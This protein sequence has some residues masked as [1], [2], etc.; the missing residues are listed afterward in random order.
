M[1]PE[2]IQELPPILAAWSTDSDALVRRWHLGSTRA[3]RALAGYLAE[4]L[5]R[6]EAEERIRGITLEIRLGGEDGTNRGD[7]GLAEEI[8]GAIHESAACA[9]RARKTRDEPPKP[10]PIRARKRS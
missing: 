10:R 5:D 3:V 9:P 7:L 4:I 6:G 2:R 8:E 1:K